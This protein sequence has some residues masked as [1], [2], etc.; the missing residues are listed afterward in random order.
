MKKHLYIVRLSWDTGHEDFDVGDD[1]KFALEVKLKE[2][3]KLMKDLKCKT[4]DAEKF[5]K[6]YRL[7]VVG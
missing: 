2:V 5:V 4:E 6:V 7:E 3:R 1:L